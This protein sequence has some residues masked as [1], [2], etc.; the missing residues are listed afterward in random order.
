MELSG[1]R[2]E[3]YPEALHEDGSVIDLA[4]FAAITMDGTQ[5]TT[6]PKTADG[7]P[8]ILLYRMF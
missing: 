5:P 6:R 7:I 1:W 3:A 8:N 2:P 4:H